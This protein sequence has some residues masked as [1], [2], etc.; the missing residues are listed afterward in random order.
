M[1]NLIR[2]H[3]YRY[4]FTKL[5]ENNILIY[6]VVYKDKF[7]NLINTFYEGIRNNS[8]MTH[9]FSSFDAKLRK[10]YKNCEKQFL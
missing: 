5:P 4:V 1:K 9:S 10:R 8:Y 6:K 2:L 7:Q 3:T